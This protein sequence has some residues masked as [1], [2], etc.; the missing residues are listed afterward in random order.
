MINPE[1]LVQINHIKINLESLLAKEAKD[2]DETVK[3]LWSILDDI[4]RIKSI[5]QNETLDTEIDKIGSKVNELREL[6]SK[7]TLTIYDTEFETHISTMLDNI[8]NIIKNITSLEPKKY[9]SLKLSAETI[10]E[11][12]LAI[13]KPEPLTLGG[14]R[15]SRKSRKSGRTARRTRRTRRTRITRRSIKLRRR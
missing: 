14:E 2:L 11:I 5:M 1:A 12:K 9:Y 13:N 6:L 4:K 8:N 3:Y 7:K 10:E 15:K